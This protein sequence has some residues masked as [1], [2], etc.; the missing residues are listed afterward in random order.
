MT[1]FREASWEEA[2]SF[3]TKRFLEIKTTYGAESI[4]GMGSA[5]AT[6]EDNYLFQRMM[7]AALGTNNIDNCARL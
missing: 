4:G 6:N 3:I 2:L 1:T 5:R 7:R